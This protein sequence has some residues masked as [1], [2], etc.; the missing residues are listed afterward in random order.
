MKEWNKKDD[1]ALKTIG[2]VSLE[3]KIP[4]HVLRFWETKFKQ[5]NPQKRR[6][7][8]YYTQTDIALVTYI[9]DLLYTQKYTLEG[10]KELLKDKNKAKNL[11]E[12]LAI[13]LV[14]VE[15]SNFDQEVL[16]QHYQNLLI[17]KSK[18]IAFLR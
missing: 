18:L 10:V 12:E 17:M 3:V 9:Q 15:N 13:E 4:T 16:R 11:P 1:F 7:I 8:R 2:E 6:G 14:E 5:L